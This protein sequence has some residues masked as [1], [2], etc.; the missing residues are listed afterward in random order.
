MT[1]TQTSPPASPRLVSG[2]W[3]TA[4][5]GLLTREHHLTVALDRSGGGDTWP[6]GTPTLTVYAREVARA[7]TGATS[8]A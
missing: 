3:S 1:P 4:N 5:A 7:G 6:D 8:R 2:P